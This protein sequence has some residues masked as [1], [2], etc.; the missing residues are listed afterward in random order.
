MKVAQE[1]LP[2]ATLYYV[3]PHCYVEPI[4]GMF[5][6]LQKATISFVMTASLPV[7][8]SSW[9]NSAPTGQICMKSDISVF[10]KNL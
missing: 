8:P 4:L 1:V 5:T 6:K 9:N 3:S 10:F 7:H 2:L